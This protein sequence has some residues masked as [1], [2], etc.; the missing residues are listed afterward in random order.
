VEGLVDTGATM[1]VMVAN[2]MRELGIMHLVI[3]SK[4]YKIAFGMVM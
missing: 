1:L 4:S 3:G 2:V